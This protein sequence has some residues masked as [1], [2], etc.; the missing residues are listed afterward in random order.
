MLRDS[1]SLQVRWGDKGSTEEGAKLEKAKNA[2]VMMPAP[3]EY[4]PSQPHYNVHRPNSPQKWYSP[5]KVNRLLT[6]HVDC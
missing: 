1:G 6:R 3:E 2:R 4:V 5:I